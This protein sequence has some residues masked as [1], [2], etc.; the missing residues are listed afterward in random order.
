MG[1]G[2]LFFLGHGVG[3]ATW[4]AL[5]LAAL[6]GRPARPDLSASPVASYLIVLGLRA[7]IH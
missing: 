5:A 4:S 6:M 1:A 3:D 2:S 7:I